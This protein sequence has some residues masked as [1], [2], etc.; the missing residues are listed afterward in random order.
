[1]GEIRVRV[2]A[3]SDASL[4]TAFAPLEESA[5][6]ARRKVGAETSGMSREQER[7]AKR[8]IRDKIREAERAQRVVARDEGLA[9][10]Q[11]LRD[12][13]RSA[14]E[15]ER[16][17]DR[18]LK[19]HER[20]TKAK[21]KQEL[22][23]FDERVRA[24]KRA[25][26]E[27]ERSISKNVREAERN[28]AKRERKADA[29][30]TD[31]VGRAKDFAGGAARNFAGIARA[32]FG[33]V[34]EVA[35]GAGVNLDLS[36][37]VGRSVSLNRQVTE[38]QNAGFNPLEG[39]KRMDRGAITGA[40]KGA[41]DS[42][43]FSRESAASG[44]QQFVGKTGELEAGMKV[45][46]EMGKLS[47]ATG[48]DLN[49]MAAAAGEVANALGDM[50]NKAEKAK[51]V[52]DLMK[53][54][55]FQGKLGSVE[56]KDLST[57]MSKL[58]AAGGQFDGNAEDNL[59]TMGAL[60]QLAKKQGGAASANQAATSI[61]GMANTFNTPARV[62]EFKAAGIDV[63]NDKTGKINAPE[64]LIMASLAKTAGDKG[65]FKKLFANVI[66]AKPAEGLKRTFDD[67]RVDALGKGA[68]KEKS[69]EVGLAAAKAQLNSFRPTD[70]KQRA[71]MDK[72]VED[73][74]AARMNDADSK[75][76]VFQNRMEDIAGSLA[77]RLLPA[78][79]KAAPNIEKFA[80]AMA[81]AA[82]WA[83]ENFGKAVLAA[84]VAS[85]GKEAI[86]KAIGAGIERLV[87]GGAG[88]GTGAGAKG[89]GGMGNL[90]A[91]LAIAMA[92]ITITAAG[93]EIIDAVFDKKD[94]TENDSIIQ[95]G[96]DR[97]AAVN[98]RI[99]A[100]EGRG[101][102]EQLA[103]LEKRRAEL[104]SS[105]ANA[106]NAPT[107]SKYVPTGILPGL[108]FADL[109]G[110]ANYATAGSLGTSFDAQGKAEQDA[111][112]LED[113]KAALADVKGAI[114]AM[115]GSTLQVNV[116]NMPAAGPQVDTAARTGP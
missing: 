31:R 76:Q 65:A 115:K 37:M 114:D 39:G 33:G 67:A 83:S 106:E 24:S 25:Q 9:Q 36:G 45:L 81:D 69:V 19:A 91:G 48:A 16:T 32:G 62:A 88:G 86:G 72:D 84:I 30:R 90:G 3:V 58:G 10:K 78:L 61:A 27:E 109:S 29:D 95:K 18:E 103:A 54:F 55:A 4:K 2:L 77:D 35:R 17:S 50:P 8:A 42:T 108:S 116:V 66:G 96:Q 112:T 44:L 98:A 64:Q 75:A 92:A 13:D 102:P 59:V 113:N 74:F 79:E 6:R 23:Y 12:A 60:V 68:T 94:K 46:P 1:M 82:G 11:R 38:L 49:D 52:A 34:S 15:I 73:S 22:R 104:E 100:K 89:T 43:G 53:V 87:S 5:A 110:A 51:K 105:V 107:A 99:A 80:T 111:K 97:E 41:A 57:Q 63:Y 56:I 28:A 7:E 20:A 85:I 101:T 70:D 71:A 21:E 14:R 40:I 93:I 47:K 26:Q